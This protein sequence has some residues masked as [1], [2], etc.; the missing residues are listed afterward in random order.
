MS[1]KTGWINS[2]TAFIWKIEEEEKLKKVN[3]SRCP[4]PLCLSAPKNF[5]LRIL[6]HITRRFFICG[7]LMYKGLH[8]HGRTQ[9]QTMVYRYISVWFSSISFKKDEE[10]LKKR[11][12]YCQNLWLQP[13]QQ[14]HLKKSR[15]K[16]IAI[17]LLSRKKTSWC[18]R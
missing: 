9:L 10:F 13:K 18:G 17:F 7:A 1:R 11:E 8:G 14:Y 16:R 6:D 5:L 3:L 15:K 4:P 2:Q 12:I